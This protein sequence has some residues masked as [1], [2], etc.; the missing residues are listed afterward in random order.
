MKL[1]VQVSKNY[2]VVEIEQDDIKLAQA[3]EVFK[4]MRELAIK[5]V[6]SISDAIKTEAPKANFTKTEVKERITFGG[7][8]LSQKQI[9][10]L[11]KNGWNEEDVKGKSYNDLQ[12]MF[13]SKKEAST[14]ATTPWTLDL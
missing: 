3:P 11:T 7:I 13:K 6:N 8:E 2:Q 10:L 4:V 1:R 14:E 12:P 9:D 5:E